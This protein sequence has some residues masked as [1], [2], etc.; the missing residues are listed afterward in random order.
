MSRKFII[1]VQETPEGDLMIEFP[2]EI[3]DELNLIEGDEVDYEL[4]ED[5]ESLILKKVEK[6][7]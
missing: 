6:T 2:Q 4:G 5:G 7:A 1:E 3:V